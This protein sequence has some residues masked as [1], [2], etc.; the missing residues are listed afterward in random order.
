MRGVGKMYRIYDRPQDRLKQMLLWRLGRSYGQEFWALRDVSFE[1]HRGET[2]GIIGR[3][4]SGKSTLLQIIAGTLAPTTG[5]VTVSG[6]VAALLELG[7]GFNPEFT[8]RENVFMNAAILGLSPAEVAARFDAIAAF[9]DIGPFLEQPVKLYS[10]GMLMRLAFA[11]QAHIEPDLLI[12]D[13]ALSVGDAYFQHKCMRHI[14]RLVDGGTTL[15]F[16][17]H[18]T[19]TV[20]RLCSRGLY[21]QDGQARYFG[22]AGVAV[23]RY[24]AS[25]RMQAEE[26]ALLTD[27]PDLE[28]GVNAASADS[29]TAQPA[30]EAPLHRFAAE[31][32]LAEDTVFLRGH[33]RAEPIPLA[34][35]PGRSCAD[36]EAVAAFRCFGSQ[37]DLTFARG[38]QVCGARVVIDGKPREIELWQPTADLETFSFALPDGE[39]T[40]LI[41]PHRPRD[42]RRV[43]WAGGRIIAP[44]DSIPFRRDAGFGAGEDEVGRYGN[45]KARLTA[46]ELLDYASGQPVS[47]LAPGQR[48]RLRLHAERLAPT[49][50]RLE[51]SFIVRDRNRLDLFGS[52]TADEGLRLDA[53]ARE[54]SVEFAF[55]INLAPG[56]YSVLAAFVECSEDFTTRVPMDQ[57]DIA[58]TFTVGHDPARPVWYMF[59]ESLTSRAQVR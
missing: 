51:F 58:L 11:V 3:N 46:A 49:A 52:T 37:I 8:G 41:S 19:D 45:G 36:P 50:P 43:F 59:R 13:E 48:V 30:V 6:R 33:W 42:G 55:D 28:L 9:A 24:L 54:F 5:D 4:G 57:I 10:S 53:A 16:V 31:I 44:A 25:L 12:V 21:L 35:L 7:S 22:S 34:G 47:E 1:V 39:H 20:K 2:V 23:E 17:S 32:S 18:S 14:K 27:E 29:L 56:P 38:P 26:A 40:V 15:L